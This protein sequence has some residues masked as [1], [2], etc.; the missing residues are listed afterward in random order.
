MMKPASMMLN[1]DAQYCLN[2]MMTQ[3]RT[4][5]STYVA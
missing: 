3:A 5:S 1:D 4:R 2:I